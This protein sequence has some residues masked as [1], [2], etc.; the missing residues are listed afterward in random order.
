MEETAT[1]R[2]APVLLERCYEASGGREIFLS[3]EILPGNSDGP[4]SPKML[5]YSV[6]F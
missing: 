6:V 4:E 2:T 5:L 3:Y 1:Q